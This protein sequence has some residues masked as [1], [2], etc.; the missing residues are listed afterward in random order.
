MMNKAFLLMVFILQTWSLNAQKDVAFSKENFPNQKAELKEA[1]LH[2]EDGD[3]YFNLGY[4]YLQQALNKYIIANTFNSNSAEL[5]YKI[6]KCYLELNQPDK[7]LTALFKARA[8][9]KNCCDGLYYNIAKSYQQALKFDSSI[10]FYKIYLNRLDP[11]NYKAQ[12]PRINQAIQECNVGKQLVSNP[13]S[14]TIENLGPNINSE[15][16]DYGVVV[17]MDESMLFYTSRRPN[18]TGGFR[19]EADQMF[20]E[21]SYW[22]LRQN[23]K[24]L[25]NKNM[26]TKINTEGH[27]A[28]VG[29][30]PDGQLLIL[31][32]D[33]N[34]GDLFQSILKGK[35]WTDPVALPEPINT[36]YQESSASYSYNGKR[37]FF[38]SDRPK[39]FGGKD[40]YYTDLQSDGKWGE[41][42]NLGA[43]VNTAGDEIAVF[44][45]PDGKTIYF[46]SNTHLGMGDFDVFRSSYVNDVWSTPEN[47]GYPINNTGSDVF[48]A[49]SASGKSA[50][51]SSRRTEGL[52]DQDI[53]VIRY[54][55]DD[56]K[57]SVTIANQIKDD[58]VNTT[59]ARGTSLTLLSGFV[60][61]EVTK[62]AIEASLELTDNQTGKVI[63]AFTSNSLTGKYMISLPSGYNYGMNVNANGYLF[64]SENFVIEQDQAFKQMELN[65]NLKKVEVGKSIALNN[66]FFDYD[67]ASLNNESVSELNRLVILLKEYPSIKIQVE[68]H[69][70]NVGTHEYNQQLSEARAKAVVDYLISKGIDSA[71]L[72]YMGFG[73]SK[74]VADNTEQEG[75]GKNRRSEFKIIDK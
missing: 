37:L 68:G 62:V 14:V 35:D 63:A 20:Y 19:N 11:E 32:R 61:D 41:A 46:S 64:H 25:P 51:V 8:L 29:I 4:G 18:T 28:P 69:T 40:I 52:G 58:K 50:Y 39:G 6:G 49:L 22:S 47:L 73:Y 12:Q 65:I 23:G 24:W 66:I 42:I 60:M 26:G 31:Y 34:G 2:I 71:R 5:N 38:V 1:I 59:N 72:K 56:R 7:S 44:C 67:K 70:D 17:N 21:D 45:M 57:D 33:F 9:N 74:P 3:M 53:Y 75:R 48:F 10:F 16:P 27:D 43:R 15:F 54:A 30:S 55:D 36:K 13:V